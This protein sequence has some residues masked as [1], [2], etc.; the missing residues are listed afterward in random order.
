MVPV[1]CPY[2]DG[3]T[4]SSV[5]QAPIAINNF[6]TNIDSPLQRANESVE[7]GR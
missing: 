6:L 3:Q 2:S 5:Q 1:A 4:Q 7:R